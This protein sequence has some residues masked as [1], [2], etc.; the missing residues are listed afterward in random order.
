MKNILHV[1][2]SGCCDGGGSGEEMA[3]RGQFV[4]GLFASVR[5]KGGASRQ[6]EAAGE[7]NKIG[8]AVAA[9]SM[10]LCV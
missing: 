2:A 5:S 4:G 9:I 6:V 3:P 8:H 10:V 7:S 1:V